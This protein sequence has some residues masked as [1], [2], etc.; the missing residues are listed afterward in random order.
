MWQN[1][2]WQLHPGSISAD[3]SAL[4]YKSKLNLPL[5]DIIGKSIRWVAISESY[6]CRIV[7]GRLW[8]TAVESGREYELR[9]GYEKGNVCV[10]VCVCDRN[11][12]SVEGL[13]RLSSRAAVLAG[14]ANV[15]FCD[16]SQWTCHR[17]TAMQSENKRGH[18]S[19]LNPLP[20]S[21][22]PTHQASCHH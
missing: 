19:S 17:Q 13:T 6:Y 12:W 2:K 22:F 16:C 1:V 10:C 4:F 21:L 8:G 14:E 15:I 9:K 18:L 3:S 5:N 11:H 7:A 20:H